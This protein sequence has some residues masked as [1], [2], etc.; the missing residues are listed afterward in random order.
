MTDKKA[1]PETKELSDTDLDK[2]RGAGAKGLIGDEIGL[3][4]SGGLKRPQPKGMESV[5]DDE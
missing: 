3:P 5:D 4:L 2:V 1:K